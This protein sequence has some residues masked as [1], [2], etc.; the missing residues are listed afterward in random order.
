MSQGN[1]NDKYWY[2]LVGA[3]SA[4]PVE[5]RADALR[6][7]QASLRRIPHIPNPWPS[8]MAQMESPE[9]AMKTFTG[10]GFALA[11]LVASL[12]KDATPD[13]IVEAANATAKGLPTLGGDPNSPSTVSFA[14]AATDLALHAPSA[15]NNLPQL[16]DLANVYDC[17]IHKR[18]LG[19][20]PVMAGDTIVGKAMRALFSPT[21][22]ANVANATIPGTVV[23]DS[24]GQAAATA[25]IVSATANAGITG[26]PD[27]GL[28]QKEIESLMSEAKMA[29]TQ[30]EDKARTLAKL[31]WAHAFITSPDEVADVLKTVDPEAGNSTE[32]Y[33]SVLSLLS[34]ARQTGNVSTVRAISDAVGKLMGKS[35]ATSKLTEYMSV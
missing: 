26:I 18:P 17:Y 6:R 2:L 21:A 13:Q 25:P 19:G 16:V 4:I 11:N 9:L 1:N 24:L 32:L 31:N 23:A 30:A 8:I 7:A 14:A 10:G 34:S 12:G 28:L 35:N 20:S 3:I 5:D 15:V 27:P 22:V 29:R 33:K